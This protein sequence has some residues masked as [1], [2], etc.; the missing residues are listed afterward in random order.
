M[1]EMQVIVGGVFIIGMVSFCIGFWQGA[2]Q[3]RMH[4][5]AVD[6]EVYWDNNGMPQ[7]KQTIPMPPVKPPRK[8]DFNDSP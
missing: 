4:T 6:L 1:T 8:E 3:Q 5:Q 2:R 7:T